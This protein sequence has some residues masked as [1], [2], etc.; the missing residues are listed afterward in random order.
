M[1]KSRYK[2]PKVRSGYA[3]IVPLIVRTDAAAFC[4]K[5]LSTFRSGPMIL[6][7]T[8][9]LIPVE[10]MLIRFSIGYGQALATPGKLTT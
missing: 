9:V 2:P 6:M 7:P 4:A 8:G 10:S 3:L 5:S 1:S